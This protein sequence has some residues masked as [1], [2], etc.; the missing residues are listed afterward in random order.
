MLFTQNLDNNY[1]E[2][3]ENEGLPSNHIYRITQD[4]LGNIWFATNR[5]LSQFNGIE[6][7]NFTYKEGLPNQNIW[8][9]LPDGD[10]IWIFSKHK[11]QGYIQHDKVFVFSSSDDSFLSPSVFNYGNDEIYLLSYLDLYKFNKKSWQKIHTTEDYLNHPSKPFAGLFLPREKIQLLF[12]QDEMSVKTKNDKIYLKKY[13]HKNEFQF[14]E[15]DKFFYIKGLVTPELAY[16]IL[17]SGIIFINTQTLETHFLTPKQLNGSSSLKLSSKVDFVNGKI[18]ISVPGEMIVMDKNL[19]EQKRFKYPQFHDN[20]NSFLDKS[21]NLW[22][23][24]QSQL[25][26]Y[27]ALNNSSKYYLKNS[28]IKKIQFFGDELFAGDETVPILKYDEISDSFLP[29]KNISD[30]VIIRMKDRYMISSRNVY[31]YEKGKLTPISFPKNDDDLKLP[32][33]KDFHSYKGFNYLLN[34]NYFFQLDNKTNSLLL[35]ITHSNLQSIIDFN[36]EIYIGST[37]GLIKFKN[38]KLEPIFTDKFDYP[39][40]TFLKFRD[41]LLIGTNGRGIYA[42]K[43]NE[44]KMISSTD[45]LSIQRIAMGE[46]NNIWIS[47]QKGIKQLKVSEKNI[48]HSQIINTFSREDGLL[49]NN[50]NDFAIDKNILY[51]A[52]DKGITKIDWQNSIYYN[53]VKISFQTDNDTLKISPDQRDNIQIKFSAQ[54]FNSNKNINYYYRLLPL[55]NNWEK[56]TSGELNF[57]Q[58]KHGIY[59]LEVKSVTPHN[60]SSESYLILQVFPKWW[61]KTWVKICAVVIIGLIL[62]VIILFS[63]QNIKRNIKSKT[64]RKRKIAEIEL[65]A[66][67][68]QMNPHF[69]H[70]SLNAIQ[71]YIKNSNASESEKYLSI[72]SRLIRMFFEYSRKQNV[73]V[74]DEIKLLEYYLKMEKLRFEDKLTYSILCEPSVLEEETEIPSMLLQPLV[75]NAVNHGVFHKKEGGYVNIDISKFN[76]NTIKINVDDNGIG[77]EASK[78]INEK[79]NSAQEKTENSSTVLKEKIDLLNRQKKEYIQMEIIHKSESGKASGTTITLYIKTD[80]DEN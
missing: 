30:E 74:K 37:T 20:L 52:S 41:F 79:I 70:N 78:L 64:E 43:N 50:T 60:V 7:K 22:H 72:F 16:L 9:L 55:Q 80:N 73:L 10:K 21:G 45:G 1:I 4:N 26:F 34:S 49:Q 51:I 28:R 33:I 6:F 5:G 29:F 62:L 40:N 65:N 68:S 2:Y 13:T 77:M 53:P 32:N 11:K 35:K 58:L 8:E 59:Q 67:R 14:S 36:D 42:L 38:K 24:N 12:Y 66:L 19:K 44:I 61:E 39:V 76:E 31:L 25:L 27:S 3:S 18:H 17:S 56:A 48:D 63:I 46:E 23:N 47:T 54:G 57:N 69:V 71:Y 15:S 75:E